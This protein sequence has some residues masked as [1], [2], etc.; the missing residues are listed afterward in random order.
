MEKAAAA[1]P[2]QD[3]ALDGDQPVLS[4]FYCC[5]LLQSIPKPLSFYIG[6][7][8]NP[9]RRF[10]QH[11]GSLAGGAMRT[12]REGYAPW[13]PVCLVYGFVEHKGALRFEHAW[14]NPN[15]TRHIASGQRVLTAKRPRLLHQLLATARLLLNAP[16]FRDQSLKVQFFT[17][18]GYAAWCTNR[19]G[20]VDLA[21]T[22]V[23]RTSD[24]IEAFMQDTL[25]RDMAVMER[26]Q[27][28]A[29][30]GPH[31]CAVCSDPIAFPHPALVVVCHFRDCTAV[32]HAVCL[33]RRFATA[34]LPP[35]LIPHKGCCPGCTKTVVWAL[36]A[37]GAVW[38]MQTLRED[39]SSTPAPQQPAGS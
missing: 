5:Y 28:K 11:N 13:Q 10:R 7:T 12:T 39:G 27:S 14:D 20:V 22:H 4:P 29:T 36:A 30:A 21:T 3:P 18:T 1:P 26:L 33:A 6:S 32:S 2:S 35:A 9:V 16:Y 37:R 38:L 23:D 19:H 25:R 31:R 17:S 34:S 15:I 24:G 8:P